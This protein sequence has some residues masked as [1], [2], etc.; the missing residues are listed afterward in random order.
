MP[1]GPVATKTAPQ[2]PKLECWFEVKFQQE[3]KDV[4]AAEHPRRI[5]SSTD[6]LWDEIAATRKPL[7]GSL[8]VGSVEKASNGEFIPKTLDVREHRQLPWEAALEA[9]KMFERTGAIW[10]TPIAD[11]AR[12]TR[13]AAAEERAALVNSFKSV[14]EGLVRGVPTK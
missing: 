9:M 12:A 14:V 11:Q 5:F 2:A 6:P 10:D 3:W 13:E 8:I 1:T 7:R 4:I